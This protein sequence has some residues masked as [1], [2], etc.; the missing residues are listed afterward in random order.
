MIGGIPERL[1]DVTWFVSNR[2]LG[3]LLG[4]MQLVDPLLPGWVLWLVSKGLL[5]FSLI[6]NHRFLLD[7]IMNVITV[8][9]IPLV[10]CEHGEED[11][12]D[13]ELFFR[14]GVNQY[15]SDLGSGIENNCNNCFFPTSLAAG[16]LLVHPNTAPMTIKCNVEIAKS[17]ALLSLLSYRNDDDIIKCMQKSNPPMLPNTFFFSVHTGKE[18]CDLN[19]FVAHDQSWAVFCFRGTEPET[20][21]D[22]LSSVIL[23]DPASFST[24]TFDPERPEQMRVAKVRS[25]YFRLM[26][27]A[28]RQVALTFQM[29][30]VGIVNPI[31]P[32]HSVTAFKLASYLH[33][34]D[35]CKV[36]YTGHSLGGGL[37]TLMG[38]DMLA[39]ANL[40]AA[41]IISFG[42]PSVGDE[43]FCSWFNEEFNNHNDPAAVSWRFVK[44]DEFAPMAPPLPFTVPETAQQFHHVGG[45]ILV[46]NPRDPNPPQRSQQEMTDCM[47]DLAHQ[48][49]LSKIIMDHN[50]ASTLRA[51]C[52]L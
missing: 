37:A 24:G 47:N 49:N 45:L 3:L 18:D 5:K 10:T 23:S 26:E 39:S 14:L 48:G 51:L 32:N 46:E 38:A 43:D 30:P 42:S 20:L 2:S 44:G 31:P 21:R 41:G 17:C 33:R 27:T 16:P 40:S 19:I 9:A 50:L 52:S 13:V 1:C 28:S 8:A 6:V 25:Q 12:E 36:Y 29:G 22:W 4:G 11:G 15:R 35:G 34:R 7:P